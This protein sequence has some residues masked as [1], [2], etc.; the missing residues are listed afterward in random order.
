ML[1]TLQTRERRLAVAT[2]AVVALC[3]I[4][5]LI[6]LPQLTT[7]WTLDE[8][9]AGV[10]LDLLEMEKALALSERIDA[11]YKG[12]ESAL[13]QKGS[14]LEEWIGFLRT[15]SDLTAANEMK[16]VS[17]EQ[18]PVEVGP[19]HKLYSVRLGVQTRPVWLARFL[20]SLQKSNDLISVEDIKITALDDAENLA[21]N[22]KLTK[23]VAVKGAAK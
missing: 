8:K 12:Y 15:V 23:V 16:L 10:S 21:V 13:S 5:R 22:M 19:F 4:Y 7:M 6:V 20:S 11:Q 1:H 18:P 9:A 14:D 17:Q 3:V 2:A